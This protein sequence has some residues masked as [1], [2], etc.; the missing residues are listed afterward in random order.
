[1]SN[2]M[3]RIGVSGIYANQIALNTTG[4]NITNVNTQG[5]S[6][7]RVEFTAEVMGGVDQVT[8]NRLM[9]Q[10]AQ[11][12]LRKDSSNLGFAQSYLDQANRTDKLLGDASTSI[13]TGIATLFSRVNSMNDEASNL[14]N[15]S[16]ALSE[17]SN[18]LATYQ[19]QADQFASQQDEVNKQIST[20][21]DQ[22]NGLIGNIYSL[23]QKLGAV[24]NNQNDSQRSTLLDQ[25]DDYIRQLS[26]L[27]DVQVTPANGDA[28]NVTMANGQALV[29]PDSRATVQ[30]IPGDPEQRR[31]ELSVTLGTQSFDVD[32]DSV[33]GKLGG[34]GQFRRDL[35]EPAQRQLG[36]MALSMCDAFNKQ[37]HLGLDL[38]G[39]LGGDIFS[40]P[41]AT[42]YG[43]AGNSS[44][45]HQVT[46]TVADGTQLTSQDYRIVFTSATDYEIQPLDENGKLSGT[47]VTG[48]LPAQPPVIDGLQLN[49]A[50]AT[51]PGAFAAGD[52]FELK[53]TRDA[54]SQ[55]QMLMER[56]QELALASPIRVDEGTDNLGT[57]KLSSL[58]VTNTDAATSGFSA[59]PPPLLDSTAPGKIVFLSASQ[60]QL[61]DQS[62]ATIG[63]PTAYDPNTA[64][65]APPLDYGFSMKLSGVPAA[66]DSFS[67]NANLDSA[68]GV[69]TAKSDNSNGLKLAALQ[70]ADLVRTSAAGAA[71]VDGQSLGAAFAAMVT[72]VGDKTGSMKVKQEAA[73]ALHDESQGRLQ[74]VSGVNLDEE[75][76]N[77]IQFQQAYSATA[78]ILSTAQSVF[79]NLLKAIG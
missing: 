71:T 57:A 21:A 16:L 24:G 43:F 33:G 4:N 44:P 55:I 26:E 7:Q 53:P 45:N 65:P 9:D 25:R 39:N 41:T 28:V 8:V 38:N 63:G 62:G 40:L 69:M 67:L 36:Q 3:M 34:L 75:A 49:L 54:A 68:T 61:Y 27:M 46:A 23:N 66:G 13:G 73:Q 58:S 18:M 47:S 22:A 30:A 12:Q 32:A 78:R 76:A 20:Y 56:P 42:A 74:A 64:I 35:L 60:Y 37:Q 29:L 2:E 1:M 72:D 14:P 6:R 10:F 48:T 79:D 59:T 19:R 17:M 77:L 15:R 51:P 31:L 70:N 5:Y 50:A 11:S 52:T